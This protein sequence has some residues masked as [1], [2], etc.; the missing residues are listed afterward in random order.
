MKKRTLIK[1]HVTN[2]NKYIVIV[3]V[4]SLFPVYR[5]LTFCFVKR[6]YTYPF[7]YRTQDL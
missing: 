6:R 5:S 1:V 2:A 4:F 7:L 3:S